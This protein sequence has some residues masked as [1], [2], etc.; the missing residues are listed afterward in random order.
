QFLNRPPARVV[1]AVHLEQL[2]DRELVLDTALLQHDPDPL[3]QRPLAARRIHPEHAD[4]APGALPIALENLDGRG[5]AGAVG[6][7][8]TED[9]PYPHLEAHA[10]HSLDRS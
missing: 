4:F 10:T 2:G 9:L 8:Q 7:E 1:A 5:L 3:A 6:P